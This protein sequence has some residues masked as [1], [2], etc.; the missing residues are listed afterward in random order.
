M[1]RKFPAP[2]VVALFGLDQ[3]GVSV[4]GE[5]PTGLP[6][7]HV[8][9]IGLS[10]YLSLIPI[11]LAV[12]G[13]IMSEGLL[14]A[15]EYASKYGDPLDS[16]ME[17]FA[18]GAANLATGLTGGLVIAASS[19]RTAAMDSAGMRSQIP[20]ISG[21]VVVGI[22]LLFLTDLLALVPNAVLGGI[23]ANA[24]LALIEVGE[25]AVIYRLRRSEFWIAVVCM[26]SVLAL[27]PLLAV[28]IAFLL[29]AVD[30]VR[31]AASPHTSVMR[32]LPDGRGY[33][34]SRDMG[35]PMTTPGLIL[36]RF[37]AE[38]F[39]ANANFFQERVKQ[40]VENAG[41]TVKW[42]VLDAEAMHDIDTTGAEALEQII[43]Y[44]EKRGITFALTREQPPFR[45]LLERY[46]LVDR[47][48]EGRRYVTNRD[49]VAAFLHEA[50]QTVPAAAEGQDALG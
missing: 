10:D 29:S 47:I 32:P 3:R 9:Q 26:A 35:G 31:R 18:F 40:A 13:I 4:L 37:G 20:S 43:A 12:V 24:V 39:F 46:G 28:I 21:A 23:V 1:R 11:A 44:L 34:P 14:V 25:L 45:Q 48:G 8:P 6:S 16:D 49:A 22:V 42:F 36:F 50:G 7:F 38:L 17:L 2:L 30:V 41:G 15:R 27:G 33:Y 5:I 19:S